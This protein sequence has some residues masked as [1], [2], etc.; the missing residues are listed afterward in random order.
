MVLFQSQR[1]DMSQKIATKRD[2][3]IISREF[4]SLVPFSICT[5]TPYYRGKFIKKYINEVTVR[6]GSTEIRFLLF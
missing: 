4:V 5:F 3:V 6:R 2:I 1:N